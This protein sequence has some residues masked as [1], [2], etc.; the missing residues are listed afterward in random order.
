MSMST[1]NGPLVT[2]LTAAHMSLADA[3]SGSLLFSRNQATSRANSYAPSL[4]YFR[5]RAAESRIE[6]SDLSTK[7]LDCRGFENTHLGATG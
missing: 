1:L 5:S 4:S 2:Q 7:G 6:T 3:S